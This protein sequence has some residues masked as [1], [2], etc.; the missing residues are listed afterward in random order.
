MKKNTALE[1]SLDIKSHFLLNNQLNWENHGVARNKK[2][3][4]KSRVEIK[5][6]FPLYWGTMIAE[7]KVENL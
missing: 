7:A 5:T 4:L 2:G 1:N 3:I 6:S